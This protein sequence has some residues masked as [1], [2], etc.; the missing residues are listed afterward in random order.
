MIG[1]VKKS[2]HL[3]AGGQVGGLFNGDQD[4][5]GAAIFNGNIDFG[6]SLKTTVSARLGKPFFNNCITKFN[7]VLPL[8]VHAHGQAYVSVKAE[9]SNVRLERRFPQSKAQ[10]I[11]FEKLKS[12]RNLAH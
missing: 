3:K 8:S 9:A 6:M 5:S 2:T 11:S 7:K 12:W 1:T 4:A 10:G